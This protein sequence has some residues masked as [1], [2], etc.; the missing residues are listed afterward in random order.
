MTISNYDATNQITLSTISG[1]KVSFS[2]VADKNSIIT[3][4]GVENGVTTT[5]VE[6]GI[7]DYLPNDSFSGREEFVVHFLNNGEKKSLSVAIKVGYPFKAKSHILSLLGDELIGSDI[8]AIF[9]LVKNSYDA[10]AEEVKIVLENMNT[11]EQK[12]IIED[13]G[14]GMTLDTL[15]NVWLE[16]GTDFKRGANRKVSE[17]F[18]R[19]SLGEK[20]VGRLAV[21]KLGKNITL[22]TQVEGH[23]HSHKLSFNWE[24]IIRSN[25]YINDISIGI[26]K[27]E[28]DLLPKG[29]GTRITISDLKNGDWSRAELR[30]L[31]RKVYSMKSP[32]KKVKG[33]FE[34]IVDAKEYQHWINDIKSIDNMLSDSIYSFDFVLKKDNHSDF[35]N[36]S[37]KYN[38][39]PPKNFK[40]TPRTVEHIDCSE[41]QPH[42]NVFEIKVEKESPFFIDGQR[43]LLNND[44]EGIGEISGRFYVYNLLSVILNSFG[45]THAIKRFVKENCGVKIFRDG[46]RVYNYG[47]PGDD[48][49]GLDLARVQ[50]LGSH[51]SKN[52]TIGSIEISQEGSNQSLKEK[53]N[54][55]GFDENVTYL[56]FKNICQQI[57]GLFENN[58]QSDRENLRD[59]LDG[60][61]P[62]KVGLSDSISQIYDKIAGTKLEG[63]VSP[64]LKRVERDYDDMRNVMLSS[65]MTGVNLGIVFHEVDREVRFISND[66]KN[67]KNIEII[68][69]RVKNLIQILENFSPIL[70]QN[71]NIAVTAS[72][73]VS[74]A[75]EIN[76]SRFE[77]HNIIFSSPLLTQENLDFNIIGP[78]NLFI[79][80]ISNIIDNAIYWLVNKRE[81]EQGDFKAGIY[82]GSDTHNFHGP[83]IIVADNGNGFKLE[84]EDL[85]MPYRTTKPGGMGLGLYFV[86]LVME[87]IGGELLFPDKEEVEIPKAYNG[88]ILAL[89]FSK[90]N[91]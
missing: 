1:E 25:E 50:R 77:Y 15:K 58:A 49:L 54:R 43:H 61:K 60:L 13:D 37:W 76:L 66:L 88:A 55:E 63:E 9:E 2:I 34:V 74:N 3:I 89:V 41:S 47:E 22:E 39:N 10:D 80:A 18:K 48:W 64:L 38:F 81:L 86:N 30:D 19:I 71:Q 16:I 24:N 42:F 11:P 46:I 53:T 14:T 73:I 59:Y 83:A 57:F 79:S 33:T 69:Q 23:Y 85:V 5:N 35:A 75:K 78:A 12:I 4:S 70:R 45:Q 67:D 51:F 87:L 36:L 31:V 68:K 28:A 44:I 21:H 82:I 52:V 65:G 56:K 26:E 20:G 72:Q 29:H 7:I 84:P 17:K 90:Q 40:I 8:L 91:K 6:S 62:A 32:F 27:K